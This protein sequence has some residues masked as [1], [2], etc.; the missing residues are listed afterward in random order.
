MKKKI[1]IIFGGK[2]VEHEISI[3]S[4]NSILNHI[5]L[6]KYSVFGIFIDKN[7]DF[8]E[9]TPIIKSKKLKFIIKKQNRVS[10][11][12]GKNYNIVTIQKGEV[13]SKVKIDI[14][15]PLIHG[16]GG[17]DGSI[18]G[19]LETI[20]KPYVGCNVKSSSICMDKV[21]TKKILSAES[22][23]TTKFYSY[24]K[25]EWITDKV[26][27][28]KDISNYIKLPCF[29]KA[30]N[31]GSSV[32][33]YK[34]KNKNDLKSKIN[35]AFKFAQKVLVEEA[36]LDPEEVEI[37]VLQ[38]KRTIVSRPGRVVSS[39]EFYTY[40]AKYL[41]GKSKI[42]IP[43]Q[44]AGK[45]NSLSKEIKDVS[46]KVFKILEC[47]GMARID[48]LYGKTQGTKKPLLYLSEVN[49]IPGFTEISMF[50]MLLNE[51]GITLK[52]IIDS[53]IK[54]AEVEFKKKDKLVTNLS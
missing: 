21:L 33:V 5:D 49:T 1:C 7:G 17:E 16:T 4:A 13:L 38:N 28:L 29:V 32:G 20:N 36:V 39:D 47:S 10:F 2:S 44:R 48:F 43:Y 6:K 54:S 12:S 52:K 18:Q 27:I 26:T 40:K 37:S 3:I 22:I 25:D 11:L 23:R 46:I 19:L 42:E 51:E 14:F 24:T 30:S 45:N 34:V 8:N 53:L 41:D 50:P 35:S 15:F 9:S 31:L